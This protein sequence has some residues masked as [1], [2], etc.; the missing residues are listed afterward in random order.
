MQKVV[1]DTTA[2]LS[3]LQSATSEA[4]SAT[5]L[6]ADTITSMGGMFS[7]IDNFDSAALFKNTANGVKLN[8]KA[9]SSLFSST[10]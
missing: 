6:T 2:S 4:S 5:G 3:T 7:D 1:T 8:T 10:T 9:L